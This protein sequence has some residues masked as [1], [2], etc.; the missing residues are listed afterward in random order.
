MIVKPPPNQDASVFTPTL[1][2]HEKEQGSGE[3]VHR[4]GAVMIQA[5]QRKK[6]RIAWSG[7][8]YSGVREAKLITG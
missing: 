4:R 2:W 6:A 7:N 3:S 5:K 8:V 1:F